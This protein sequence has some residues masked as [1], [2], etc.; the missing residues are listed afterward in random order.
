MKSAVYPPLGCLCLVYKPSTTSSKGAATVKMRH[1]L[2]L[3]SIIWAAA[4]TAADVGAANTPRVGSFATHDGGRTR[5]FIPTIS[6]TYM[7]DWLRWKYTITRTQSVGQKQAGN[8]STPLVLEYKKAASYKKVQDGRKLRILLLGDSI[9]VGFLS[10]ENYGDGDGYRRE[11]K[12]KLSKNTVVFAGNV[13]SGTMKGGYYAAWSGQTIQ[14]ISEHADEALSQRPNLVLLMA[15]T[16]DMNPNDAVS[17]QGHDP[18][19]ATARLGKLVDK[20]LLACPDATVI[21]AIIPGTCDSEQMQNTAPFQKLIPDMVRVRRESGQRVLVGDFSSFGMDLL[22]DCIHPTNEGYRVMGD[23]WYDFIQQVPEDWIQEPV[24]D[25]PMRAAARSGRT[26]LSVLLLLGKF[27]SSSVAYAGL[28][29][30]LH[31]QCIALLVT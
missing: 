31:E 9:T 28:T 16:N 8:S 13:K 22:R 6:N 2:I 7:F 23:Y 14:F 11:L 24:G 5:R 15:G 3:A 27:S 18:H 4:A 19:E 20:V 21:V 10:D 26:S 1:L 25:D 29:G 30:L 12:K 17:K